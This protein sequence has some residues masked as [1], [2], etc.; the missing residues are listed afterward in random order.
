MKKHLDEEGG[1]KIVKGGRT[2]SPEENK[3]GL[4]GE[5]PGR[6]IENGRQPEKTP[7]CP[8]S[9]PPAENENEGGKREPQRRTKNKEIRPE[10]GVIGEENWV[11]ETKLRPI[12]K[13]FCETP[14][15]KA[16][17]E[18]WGGNDAESKRLSPT[19]TGLSVGG[20]SLPRKMN[21]GGGIALVGDKKMGGG[22]NFRTVISNKRSQ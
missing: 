13:V 9:I 16:K 7:E 6:T 21:V 5:N 18:N 15:E 22:E 17:N 14:Q 12:D 19:T 1:G 11:A 10:G 20:K 8:N 4:E 2:F 3:G